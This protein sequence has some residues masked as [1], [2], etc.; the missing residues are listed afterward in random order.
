LPRSET[1]YRME[2][3][4]SQTKTCTW[5]SNGLAGAAEHWHA[6]AVIDDQ[7]SPKSMCGLFTWRDAAPVRPWDD[8]GL[9]QR[10]N[11]CYAKIVN[12]SPFGDA[13]LWDKNGLECL[14]LCVVCSRSAASHITGPHAVLSR[15]KRDGLL[16]SNA[17]KLVAVHGRCK[18]E[19]AAIARQQGYVWESPPP[20]EW[21]N[22]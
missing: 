14:S 8:R 6:R 1:L 4:A 9:G 17:S 3:Q 7:V 19:G 22:D 20:P 16:R 5:K 12:P 2:Y 10:C 11:V 18:D 15:P 21:H 13:D